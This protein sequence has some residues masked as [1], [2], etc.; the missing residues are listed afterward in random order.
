MTKTSKEI[1]VEV[2]NSLAVLNNER[3]RNIEE[4]CEVK[5]FV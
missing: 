4:L 3:I 5:D 1:E 2:Q